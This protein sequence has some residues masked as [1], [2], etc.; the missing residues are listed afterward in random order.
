M[1]IPN[2]AINYGFDP[3]RAYDFTPY[4]DVL[5]NICIHYGFGRHRYEDNKLFNVKFM[6]EYPNSLYLTDDSVGLNIEKDNEYFD[7]IINICPYTCNLLNDKFNTDK[8]VSSFFPLKELEYI[9]SDRPYPV[10]YSGNNIYQ[11]HIF[12]NIENVLIHYLGHHQHNHLKSIISVQDVS[13]YFRKLEIYSKTKI[14]IAH[15]VLDRALPN[16]DTFINNDFYKKHLPWHNNTSVYVPQIKS[17]MFEGAMMGCI[18]LIYKDEYNTTDDYFTENED[19]LY[20]TDENDL[21]GKIDMILADYT[22]YK[23]LAENAKKKFY[24]K[25]TFK[26]FIDMILAEYTKRKSISK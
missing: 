24:A 22:K 13:S 4:T 8:Y 20:F 23:Y 11:L 21:R 26:H 19:F 6:V 5:H 1:I 14:C 15:N 16:I 18:L 25:Y 17:R 2:F 12:R 7:L 3:Q 10:F 9:E